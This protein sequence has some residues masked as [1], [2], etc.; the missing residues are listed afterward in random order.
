[1]AQSPE[2]RRPWSTL[3]DLPH[4]HATQS[5]LFAADVGPDGQVENEVQQLVVTGKIDDGTEGLQKKVALEALPQDRP[6]HQH[7]HPPRRRGLDALCERLT[8]AF[9]S[10]RAAGRS[11]DEPGV[12]ASC[13]RLNGALQGVDCS[14]AMKHGSSSV[15]WRNPVFGGLTA[16]GEPL[17]VNFVGRLE[18]QDG[19]RK[20][21]TQDYH[22][23]GAVHL[24][25]LIFAKK[26]G[27][28]QLDEAQR[29]PA[30]RGQSSSWSGARQSGG[31]NR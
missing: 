24:H 28:M 5:L 2:L 11:R 27:P 15:R 14:G 30:T 19:K 16:E 20:E 29:H 17:K 4:P 25:G 12:S 26:I 3:H 13:P 21:A 31:Q 23:R 7:R 1:M 22:G 6:T 10:R 18:F 9:L 8:V